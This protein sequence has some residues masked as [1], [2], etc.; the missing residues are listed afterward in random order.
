MNFLVKYMPCVHLLAKQCD[1][2]VIWSFCWFPFPKETGRAKD[3][4]ERC[5]SHSQSWGFEQNI[6]GMPESVWLLLWNK[7]WKHQNHM[8]F[9]FFL[10]PSLTKHM[11]FYRWVWLR[12]TVSSCYSARNTSHYQNYLMACSDLC[13]TEMWRTKTLLRIQTFNWKS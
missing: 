9:A 6:K 7:G 13:H 3:R 5:W 10:Y 2:L 8:Q 1:K 4:F 11:I 12:N